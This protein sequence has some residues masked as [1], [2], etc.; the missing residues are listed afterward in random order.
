MSR[1][2]RALIAFAS[3]IAFAGCPASP[4]AGRL[5]GGGAGADAGNY[6]V[7]PI[8]AP[9]KIDGTKSLESLR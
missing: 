8:H 7:K 5:R 2:T 3:W 6:R 9:S 1:A 4:E